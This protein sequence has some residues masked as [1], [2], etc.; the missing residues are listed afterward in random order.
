[1]GSDIVAHRISIGLFYCKL[2]SGCV[3]AVIK[4]IFSFSDVLFEIELTNSVFL[5]IV[6]IVFS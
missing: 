3:K 5:S 4:H 1:M 2:S 6:F